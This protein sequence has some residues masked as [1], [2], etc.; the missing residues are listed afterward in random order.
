MII[1][2]TGGI[3]S[4]KSSFALKIS[5]GYNKKLFIA[6]LEVIDSETEEKIKRHRQE[7]K[8]SFTTIEEPVQIVKVLENNIRNYDIILIDCINI[9]INNLMFYKINITE[10][11]ENFIDFLKMNN[12]VTNIIVVTNEVG[13]SII[14]IDKSSR[15]FINFLGIINQKL[16]AS[17]DNVYLLVAGIPIKIKG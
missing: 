15:N 4:G 14:P 13:Q 3:K 1:L 6:T 9:W 16:A 5:D 11:V 10:Y 12:N 17:A 2:I 7:R 8:D